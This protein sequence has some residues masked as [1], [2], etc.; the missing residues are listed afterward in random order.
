MQYF[1]IFQYKLHL[2]NI[3]DDQSTRGLLAKPSCK[4]LKK[5]PKIAYTASRFL[6][7]QCELWGV[8]E[9]LTRGILSTPASDVHSTTENKRHSD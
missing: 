8:F 3:R 1:P 5:F 6:P 2:F 4:L 9:Y 7:L